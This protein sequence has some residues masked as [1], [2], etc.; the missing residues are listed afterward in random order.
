MLFP[1]YFLFRAML[2][3]R[4][5][6]N[7]SVPLVLPDRLSTGLEKGTL[8]LFR[9]LLKNGQQLQ[10]W[11]RDAEMAFQLRRYH[12]CAEDTFKAI[13]RPRSHPAAFL[14]Q[15]NASYLSSGCPMASVRRQSLA[16]LA[17]A[18]PREE[19]LFC[20]AATFAAQCLRWLPFCR[21]GLWP[22]HCAGAQ[23]EPLSCSSLCITHKTG[24][25]IPMVLL[26]P[27]FQ[28]T[29]TKHSAGTEKH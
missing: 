12:P 23:P 15:S 5:Q 6:S 16:L 17:R 22:E 21:P 25:C 14:L 9:G 7:R 1:E 26:L 2:T 8:G 3:Q 28:G 4:S 27:V 10:C 20:P 11:K 29:G 24:S 13:T 19:E 18:W